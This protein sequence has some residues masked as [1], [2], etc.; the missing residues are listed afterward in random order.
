MPLVGFLEFI[1]VSY[2][3]GGGDF[4]K[5]VSLMVKG[6]VVFSNFWKITWS[7]TG[8]IVSVLS[9]LMCFYGYTVDGFCGVEACGSFANFVGL[10]TVAVPVGVVFGYLGYGLVGGV[11]GWKDVEDGFHERRNREIDTESDEVS[12]LVK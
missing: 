6:K 9:I 8:P 3:L 11:F 5:E 12:S 2:V 4:L 7:F 10:L 1:V